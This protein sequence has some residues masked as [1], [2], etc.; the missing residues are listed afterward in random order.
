MTG[1]ARAIVGFERDDAGDWVVVLEC[2]HGQHVR[3]QPPWQERPWVLSVEGRA[4]RVGTPLACVECED[5]G[6]GVDAAQGGERPCQ[7]DRVCPECG[8]LVDERGHRRSCE[9]G[10]DGESD[11]RP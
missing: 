7:A 8:A 4:G 10:Q 11:R 2:G 5:G 6:G 3:H 9:A 1:T